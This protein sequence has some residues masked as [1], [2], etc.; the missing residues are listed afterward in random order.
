V[1]TLKILGKILLWFA[2][3]IL[4]ALLTWAAIV[5]FTNDSVELGIIMIIII[6]FIDFAVINPKGYPYR[7]TIPA[8]SL[9]LI[10]T[11]YPIFY[12][13]KI[14]FTNYGTGHL[15]T[16][17][18]VVEQL[19][20][21]YVTDEDSQP[22]SY[23]VYVHMEDFAPTEEFVLIFTDGEKR[24]LAEKPK[25]I[26]VDKDGNTTRS[27]AEYKEITNGNV[28]IGDG[29]YEIVYSIQNEDE[30]MAV[31]GNVNGNSHTYQYFFSFDDPDTLSNQ[32]MFMSNIYLKY[33]DSAELTNPERSLVR[34]GRVYGF[35]KLVDARK[36]YRIDRE[37]VEEN[38]KIL[39]RTVLINNS[40]GIKLQEE[41]GTFFEIT[42]QGQKI[43]VGGY[44]GYVGLRN[45]EKMFTDSRFTGPFIKILIWTFVWAILSVLFSFVIGLGFAL[46]LNDSKFKGRNIYRTLLLIPWAVPAFISVLV[47]RNGFFNETYGIINKIILGQWFGMDAVRWLGDAFMAKVSVLIV[48]IWL[49]FPYMMMVCL[50]A[51]QSIPGNLYEAASIDGATKIRKFSSITMPLLMTSVAPLLIGSFAFNFNN[52]TN[53]YLLTRGGPAMSDSLTNAGSTDILI[54]YT[55]KLAFQS[56][57]GQDFGYA[58]AIAL[59]I[60]IIVAGI[61]F[62]QFKFAGTFEE[63]NRG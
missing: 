39:E 33:L 16:R 41:D 59:F 54:S 30:I 17:N 24:F 21:T 46:M 43:D 47:W 7:Y 28:V 3:A 51:L 22:Y 42:P 8:L 31:E 32:R 58:S 62:F 56:E 37:M 45:F 27:I 48:N 10:L 53:I 12:T 23:S 40:T 5:L 44:R 13:L 1:I 57:R 2:L 49:G 38:G 26:S 34:F 36:K 63:V 35:R 18:Q 9:L 15:F 20:N 60:F 52:F 55:Y 4:N 6:F 14:A 29:Q 25:I 11:V 50:G 61:S 19:M